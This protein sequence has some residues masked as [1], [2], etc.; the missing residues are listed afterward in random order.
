M[1]VQA[2][3]A[4]GVDPNELIAATGFDPAI[5]ADPDARIPI[6]LEE[7][8]WSEAA[9][10]SHDHAFGLHAAEHLRPGTFDVLDYAV[11]NAPTA[12]VSLERLARYNRLVHDIATFTIV[13][14]GKVARIEHGFRGDG[15]T[16]GRHPAEF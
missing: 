10:R 7:R 13:E 9:A 5:A 12:R 6:E 1:I 11:R 3:A 16:Q 4:K 15:R 8:L 14:R 2:A